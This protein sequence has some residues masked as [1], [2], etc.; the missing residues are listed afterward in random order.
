LPVLGNRV[1]EPWYFVTKDVKKTQLI[2][3]LYKHSS[4]GEN[5]RNLV[6]SGIALIGEQ[7]AGIRPFRESV[8]RETVVPIQDMAAQSCIARITVSYLSVTPYS[9]PPSLAKPQPWNFGNGVGGHRGSGKNKIDQKTLQ[10]GENTIQSFF[11]AI[12]HGASFLE[13]DVQL[14]KDL[15]PVIYHDLLVSETGTDSPIHTL[16]FEQFEYLSQA[17]GP[18]R[19][20]ISRSNSMESAD[21]G[22]LDDLSQRMSRTH[23][24]K[25]NGF[26][27]NTRGTF[28]HEKTCTLE[29]ILKSIPTSVNL[30]IE[31]KYPMLFEADEWDL[32]LLVIK[33][34]IFVDTVLDTV[35]KYARGRTIV[36]SSFS[37][38]IC[39]AMSTKQRTWPVFFLSKTAA[40]RGEVRSSC[41]QQA[42][43]FARS[44]GLPGIVP[45]CTP[46]IKCPRLIHYVRSAGLA[47][48]SFGV[49][50][51]KP[52]C[53]KVRHPLP[54]S[55]AMALT[56]SDR[57]NST[58]VSML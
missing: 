5:G 38:E 32:E 37:P 45:E 50:N 39:I 13:F 17:Q 51:S 27:A 20:A 52:E 48:T 36:F 40:P 12:E 24:N 11:T 9:I 6:G 28:I 34:D 16:T 57:S 3:R 33:T 1:N 7:N 10:I 4:T 41:V 49:L 31:L 29:D 55:N 46:L 43:H 35:C 44:W 23:F 15:V 8:V 2:L 58:E 30:N 53:A 25:I 21:R 19:T 54:F 18:R 14:T 22:Y 56:D 47:C 26:K 42:V